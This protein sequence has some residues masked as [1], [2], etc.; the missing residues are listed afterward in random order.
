MHTTFPAAKG[1]SGVT[2]NPGETLATGAPPSR[3]AAA[4]WIRQT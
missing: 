4:V 3:R 2:M 1:S